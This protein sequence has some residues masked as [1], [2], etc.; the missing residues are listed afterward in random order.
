M[1]TPPYVRR[2][3]DHTAALREQLPRSL[4][5]TARPPVAA[6][7]DVEHERRG[8]TRRDDRDVRSLRRELRASDHPDADTASDIA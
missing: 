4:S 3:L 2:S 1:P 5:D 7:L 8:L 6:A